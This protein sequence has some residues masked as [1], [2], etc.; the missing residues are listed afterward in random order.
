[1]ARKAKQEIKLY[2]DVKI[3]REIKID[4]EKERER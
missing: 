3:G 2:T 4:Y 1:M